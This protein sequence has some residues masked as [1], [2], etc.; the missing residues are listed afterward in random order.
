[1]ARCYIKHFRCLMAP[2]GYGSASEGLRT[3]QRCFRVFPANLRKIYDSLAHFRLGVKLPIN[4][5]I[6]SW[7]AELLPKTNNLVC[8]Y[9]VGVWCN[10]V[11][12]RYYT[13]TAT[14]VL[15]PIYVG[16]M[17]MNSLWYYQ[18]TKFRFWVKILQHRNFGANLRVLGQFY[19]LYIWP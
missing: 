13:C 3:S 18:R 6:C 12:V 2:H 1:M 10:M 5:I 8:P 14:I 9:F 17:Y 4:P 7:I 19:P 11:M 16:S 15:S